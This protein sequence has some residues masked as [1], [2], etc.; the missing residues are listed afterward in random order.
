MILGTGSLAM[1]LKPHDREGFVF[2]AAGI[3]N[4]QF[5]GDINEIIKEVLFIGKES[6]ILFKD[7][8]MFVYFSTISI[9]NGEYTHYTNHKRRMEDLVRKN[10]DNYTIIRIGNIW[11]CTNPN[12]FINAIKAKQAKG[13]PVEIRDEYRYMIS[14][15][16]LNFV[17]NNLPTTGKHEISIFGEL[18]KVKDALKKSGL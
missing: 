1:L 2:C 12:T 16:Q 4:S 3:S 5:N 6:A 8:E 11:E 18:M 13:E 10:F 17:T 15:D 14:K 9:F 7:H